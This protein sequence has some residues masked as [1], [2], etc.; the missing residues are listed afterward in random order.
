MRSVKNDVALSNPKVGEEVANLSYRSLER[1][2]S[3]LDASLAVIIS[4]IVRKA[5]KL[6]WSLLLGWCLTLLVALRL[7][8][9]DFLRRSLI[10]DSRSIAAATPI[11]TTTASSLHLRLNICNSVI[12]LSVLATVGVLVIVLGVANVITAPA[13]SAAATTASTVTSESTGCATLVFSVLELLGLDSG[14]A[15]ILLKSEWEQFY[16]SV[17]DVLL[18]LLLKRHGSIL[19]VL[20]GDDSLARSLAI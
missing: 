8:L 20:E 19:S 16:E 3:N 17:S 4:N 9:A 10:I 6:G 7:V 2:T 18:V 15:L 11:A 1:Q 5:H 13:T 12:F 14:E